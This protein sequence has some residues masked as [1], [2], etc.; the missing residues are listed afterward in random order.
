MLTNIQK[1]ALSIADFC[2]ATSLGRTRVY[3][4]IRDKKLRV[5]H[6]GRRTLI[7]VEEMQAWLQ[8]LAQE[9]QGE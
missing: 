9:A 6:V 2:A 1:P 8:R 7:L 3:Q 5:I 4:E